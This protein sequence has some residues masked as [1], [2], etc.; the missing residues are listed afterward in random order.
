MTMCKGSIDAGLYDAISNT[1][2]SRR[3]QLG[4]TQSDMAVRLNAK[5][6][7]YQ[8]WEA[9]DA[10]LN[11]ILRICKELDLVVLVIPKD[12]IKGVE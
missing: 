5:R 10:T 4:I 8:R 3:K 7:T 1:I 9:G 11:S 12:Q 6:R 2:T